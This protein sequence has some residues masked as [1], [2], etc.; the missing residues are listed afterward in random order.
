MPVDEMKKEFDL[1][2]DIKQR[3]NGEIYI[4]VVGPVRTG[5][6]TFVKRFMELCVLPEMKDE[7]EKKRAIDEMPLSS[8]GQSVMTTEPKFI[9]KDGTQ[10]SLSDIHD[11]KVRLIDCVGFMVDG[12]E[13]LQE[14]GQERMVNTPWSKESI[15]FSMAA[16]IG[17]ERVIKEHST[18]GVVIT[19]DGS[20][21]G[22]DRA[23]YITPEKQTVEKLKALSKPFVMVLNCVKPYS[24]ESVKLSED[25][26]KEYGVKVIPVN[27]EQLKQDDVI[28]IMNGVVEEFPVTEITFDTPAWVE[29]LKNNHW[30]KE[31][32]LAV[33]N[34]VL[35]KISSVKDARLLP[36]FNNE[37]IEN[38]E[39]N[40]I[41]SATGKVKINFKFDKMLYYKIISELT[42]TSIN[43]EY[44]LID[45]IKSLSEKKEM[46]NKYMDAVTRTDE[47]G[48][49]VVTPVK[50]NIVM[51]EPVV[52]KNGS[53][54]GV[55]IRAKVPS[56]NMLKTQILIEIAP[57]VG[58]KTQAEDLMEYIKSNMTTNPNGIWDTNIFG[59][60]V[61]Q[62][63][64]DGIY[65]K[66]HNITQENMDK[67]GDTLEKVM[68]ENNGLVC[69]IV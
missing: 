18:I 40:Y 60:T 37:F 5:K 42:N 36:V 29:M 19:T 68:N 30:L 53:K 27:C 49:G 39:I 14:D 4:G 25:L 69:F 6:S 63:I 64:D 65:E 8:A 26:E 28:K 59:K 7:N 38:V 34:Q 24:K 41:D 32:V 9:P 15:P 31:N 35:D 56:I 3:T 22:I 50:S 66:T 1:Y 20:F 67:I 13:K 57:I 17:T 52:I 23:N 54:Y 11:V 16:K 61:G 10:I 51:D 47:C 46:L 12:A 2:K 58:N 62:I 55:K 33:A 45:M 48:F 44:E 43:N 21:T